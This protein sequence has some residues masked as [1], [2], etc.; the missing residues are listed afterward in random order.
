MKIVTRLFVLA[1]FIVFSGS[2]FAQTIGVRAG[3]SLSDLFL[4][5]GGESASENF[6]MR[7]GFH[8]GPTFEWDINEGAGIETAL[9]LTTKGVK[10]DESESY[11]G[12]TYS[13]KAKVN[14]WYLDIPVYGKL[15]ADVAKTRIYGMA[16]PYVGIGLSGKTKMEESGGGESYDEEWDIVWGPDEDDDL[17]RLELGLA[18]GGGIEINSFLFEFTSHFGLNNISPQSDY[19][20]VARNRAFMFSLGYKFHK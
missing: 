20:I 11:E 16:G 12:I 8:L 4:E 15:Y 7:S 14:L 2:L 6:S 18:V 5:E 19:D 3:Y 9:L 13:S 10:Q 1:V 17:K